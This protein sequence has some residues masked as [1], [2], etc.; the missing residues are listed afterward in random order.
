M[1]ADERTLELLERVLTRLTYAETD[2]A[3]QDAV[4]NTLCPVLGV[5]DDNPSAA[6]KQKA[7]S[8]IGTVSSL[9]KPKRTIKLPLADLLELWHRA[10][11]TAPSRPFQLIFLHMSLER[12]TKPEAA[13]AVPLLL[14]GVAAL[15]TAQQRQVLRIVLEA[16]PELALNARSLDGDWQAV[17][18][19]T[20]DRA[21]LA[22]WL[23]MLLLWPSSL[24]ASERALFEDE[25]RPLAP[26]VLAAA[27]QRLVVLLDWDGWAL[28]EIFCAVVAAQGSGNS[29]IQERAV[30]LLN[31]RRS[32]AD[33]EVIAVVEPVLVLLERSQPPV[34]H[35]VRD[36][37][38]AQL[39]KSA[40]VARPPLLAR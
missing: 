14:R 32:A 27:Q 33:M 34:S 22:H 19:S 8:C 25:K 12:L 16:A 1:D 38:M 20:A 40:I 18:Q 28:H 29:A 3:M 2:A 39:C 5:L 23:L 24:T 10:P 30:T 6:V 35:A 26:A 9:L 36:V 21:L 11:P 4:A 17:L 7:L 15:A 37:A 31:R 13:Q